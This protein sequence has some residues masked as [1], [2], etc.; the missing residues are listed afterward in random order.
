MRNRRCAEMTKKIDNRGS[1]IVSVVVIT[2]LITVLATT[3]LYV[4]AQNYITKQVDY[5]NKV[6]FYEAEK[7][8]DTLK[9]LL[10]SDVNDAYKYAYADA[11]ANYVNKGADI[12]NYYKKSF[13]DEVKS[14]WDDRQMGG[15][16]AVDCVKDFMSANLGEDSPLIDCITGVSGFTATSDKFVI[17]GITIEYTSK[18]NYSTYIKVDIALE[19]PKVN[20]A[21]TNVSSLSPINVTDSV[22]YMNWQ[23]N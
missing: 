23:R 15:K 17:N 13:V 20:F 1:A 21:T 9:A 18:N 12:D 16:A 6:S 19:P 8:L 4:S 3:L 2:A 10:A 11:M 22:I 5:Q 14:Y 7:A